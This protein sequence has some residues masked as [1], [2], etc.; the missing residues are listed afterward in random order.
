MTVLFPI[1]GSF[2]A[3]HPLSI[4]PPL[5]DL[6][7]HREVLFQQGSDPVGVLPPTVPLGRMSCPPIG[8]LPR[9]SH[10]LDGWG[11]YLMPRGLVRPD[12]LPFLMALPTSSLTLFHLLLDQ[13]D[14]SYEQIGLLD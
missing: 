10:L 13:F 7:L 12:F 5:Q 4:P 1:S 8:Q 14:I 6:L 3:R 9:P 11:L 2:L